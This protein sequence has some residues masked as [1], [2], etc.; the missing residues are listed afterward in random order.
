MGHHPGFLNLISL[1]AEIPAANDV[2]RSWNPGSRQGRASSIP[3]GVMALCSTAKYKMKMKLWMSFLNRLV[4][5]DWQQVWQICLLFSLIDTISARYSCTLEE[6][7]KMNGQGVSSLTIHFRYPL[8]TRLKA[9]DE[10]WI[11]AGIKER[12]MQYVKFGSTGMKV[13]RL[14]WA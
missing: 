6:R 14:C 11:N 5:K 4:S 3:P 10:E 1:R 7:P 13:S 2:K 12:T 8:R 9:R